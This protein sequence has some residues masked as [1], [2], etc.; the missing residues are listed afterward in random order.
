MGIGWIILG[1]VYLTDI[2]VIAIANAFVASQ[3]IFIFILL[4]P[5]SKQVCVFKIREQSCKMNFS[6]I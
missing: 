1:F 4:V 2:I 5:L 6:L 3:G